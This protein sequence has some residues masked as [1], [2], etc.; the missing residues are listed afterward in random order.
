[1]T[2][3]RVAA[4]LGFAVLATSLAAA[5]PTPLPPKEQAAVDDAVA[6]AVEFLRREQKPTGIWGTGTQANDGGYLVGY[7]ALAGLALAEAGVPPSDPALRKAALVV[8]VAAPH[9]DRTYEVALAI[10]FLDR[11]AEPKDKPAIQSLATRLIGGQTQSGGWAYKVPVAA[12]SEANQVLGALRKM[13]A[14]KPATTFGFRDRPGSLGLCI[15][16]SDDVRPKPT[17][18]QFDPEKARAEAVAGLPARFRG[19]PVFQDPDKLKWEDPPGKNQEPVGGT[20]D[21]SNTH[22]AVLG[23][24]AA[25]R[26]DVPVDRSFT[27]L[28]RRFRS[29][30]DGGGGGWGYSYAK[31]G[32]GSSPALTCVALLGLAIGNALAVDKDVG[33]RPEQDQAVLKAFGMLATKVGEPAGTFDGRPSVKDAGGLYHLWALERIAVLYDL[34]TLGNK[35]WYRW[36]M[37]VLVGHQKLDGSWAEGGFPGEHPILNTAFAVLFLK[38]ANLTPDLSKRLMADT[39]LIAAKVSE[40]PKPK[41]EAPPPPPPV[42]VVTAEPPPPPPEVKAEPKPQPAVT[43]EVPPPAVD[44]PVWPWLVGL[45]VVLGAAGLGLYFALRPR[46]EEDDEGAVAEDDE[47]E[48]PAAAFEVVEDEG[49]ERPRRKKGRHD[50]PTRSKRPGR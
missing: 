6:R 22:F 36:G 3:V 40:T 28:A 26:H 4:A 2:A 24:W 9:I 16:M 47:E 43:A 1:M 46:R 8:R 17:T 10:L 29:S 50:P 31:G 48:H 35:D 19:L 12:P 33:A 34:P 13:A 44:R 49:D 18:A 23:L 41:V 37:E 14:A 30:Q 7:T 5:Q 38:R 21:N 27:L 20:T 32:S 15:K 11:M 42:S 25:R 45:A 39:R